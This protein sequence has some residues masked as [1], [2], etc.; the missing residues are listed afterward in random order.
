MTQDERSRDETEDTPQSADAGPATEPDAVDPGDGLADDSDT[1]SEAPES[2]P[3]DAPRA[4]DATAVSSHAVHESGRTAGGGAGSMIV[5]GVLA[6]AIGAGTALVFLPEG[7]RRGDSVVMSDRL[8]ALESREAG[9][10]ADDLAAAMGAIEDR[11]AALEERLTGLEGQSGPD[12]TPIIDR[13]DALEATPGGLTEQDLNAA[14]G[15]LSQRLDGIEAGLGDQTRAAVENA[16]A[17][18]RAEIETRVEDLNSR[19]ETVAEAQERIAARA[20]LAELVAAAESGAPSPGALT[21]LTDFTGDAPALATLAVGVPTLA[22]LQ[23][24]FAP[25]ARAALAADTPEA[26][27][28]LGDR[29][30]NFLRSQTGARSLAPR[31]GDGTD[32]V[33]SRAE[34][35]LRAGDLRATLDELEAL[36]AAPA[37]AMD[38]WRA[39][40]ETRLAA[41]AALDEIQ[42]RLTGNED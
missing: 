33:L 9:V 37:Q 8:T 6:A 21:T 24:S 42:I 7:W 3:T 31:E 20:A 39:Q 41:L 25:A 17:E 10:S 5:G 38:D 22:G 18:A 12:L 29:F 2:A 32:A 26:D 4:D 34:A 30:V 27:A 11:L 14:L 40:V 13:L 23:D 28:P 19:E 15:T 16:L 1:T 35:A 36:T